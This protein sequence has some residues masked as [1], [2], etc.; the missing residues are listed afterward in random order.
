MNTDYIDLYQLHWP[1]RN[2]LVF[3]QSDFNDLKDNMTPIEEVLENLDNIVKQILDILVYQ[4][5]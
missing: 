1:E 2:A 4:M 5:K 3:G